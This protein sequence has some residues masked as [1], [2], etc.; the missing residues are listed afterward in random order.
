M[1]TE[2]RATG[3]PDGLP[4]EELERWSNELVAFLTSE[5]VPASFRAWARAQADLVDA[6]MASAAEL[7]ADEGDGPDDDVVEGVRAAPA[8]RAASRQTSPRAVKGSVGTRRVAT[9]P[10]PSGQ[11]GRLVLGIVVG[12][13]VLLAII[14]VRSLVRD[15]NADASSTLPE[16]QAPA[17]NQARAD[18]LQSLLQQDPTNKDALFELGEIMFEGERFEESIEALTKLV[19]LDPTNKLALNDIGTANFNLGR[20]DEA[21]VWWRKTLAVDPDDVQ[22]HY[23]MGFVYANAEPRDLAGA[24]SEWEAVVRLDPASQLGQT[25]K[26]HVDGLKAQLT[27]T[28]AAISAAVTPQPATAAP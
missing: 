10:L 14:G 1:I 22:A 13:V 6:Y 21:K 23:N 2:Q 19:A 12:A 26:V 27:V 7:D 15:G 8:P 18:A 28:P 4:P 11:G 20:P 9:A 24:V 17:F 16:S 5:D 25:A 3:V